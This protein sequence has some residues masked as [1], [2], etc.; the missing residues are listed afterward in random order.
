MAWTG[1]KNINEWLEGLVGSNTSTAKKVGV[2]F[3]ILLVL[4]LIAFIIYHFWQ[5]IQKFFTSITNPSDTP[6]TPDT[7]PDQIQHTAVVDIVPSESKPAP[8]GGFSISSCDPSKFH[9]HVAKD[10]QLYSSQKPHKAFVTNNACSQVYFTQG[11]TDDHTAAQMAFAACQKR[12][13]GRCG[14]V[15]VNDIVYSHI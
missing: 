2:V 3:V 13:P 12:E 5:Y 4:G 1:S 14:I 10:Y 9:E 6:D 15:A 7:P 11:Q 8:P